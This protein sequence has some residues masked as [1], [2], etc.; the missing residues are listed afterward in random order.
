MSYLGC[1]LRV[2]ALYIGQE[3]VGI[4]EECDFGE[5]ASDGGLERAHYCKAEL[6]V[7]GKLDTPGVEITAVP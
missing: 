5:H 2:G 4:L 7:R 6:A 3:A 1:L